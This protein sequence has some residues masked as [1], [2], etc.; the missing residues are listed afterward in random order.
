MPSTDIQLDEKV[1]V[2]VTEPKNWKVILLNDDVTPIEFVIS[3]LET[4]FKHSTD[5]AKH[6]TMQVHE[7]GSGVAG[8]Y[9]FE[10][11]EA[12]AVE[13]TSCAR[14]SGYPLQIKMEEE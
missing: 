1:K 14:N 6:I 9:T 11:A 3:L 10:I 5:T 2:R 13:A 8:T 12:K 4:V 7:Q